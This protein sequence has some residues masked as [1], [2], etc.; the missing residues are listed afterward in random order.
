MYDWVGY[1]RLQLSGTHDVNGPEF[2]LNIAA[3]ELRR[4]RDLNITSHLYLHIGH[5]SAGG[6]RSRDH[7]TTR[8]LGYTVHIQRDFMAVIT[9]IFF[10]NR[11]S[12]LL[13]NIL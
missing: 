4:R 11:H 5:I 8:P 12:K 9:I 7:V 3:D 10:G 1:G 6:R 2:N 13:S